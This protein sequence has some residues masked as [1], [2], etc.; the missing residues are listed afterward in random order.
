MNPRH[1]LQ[2]A[3]IQTMSLAHIE[4]QLLHAPKGQHVIR[5]EIRVRIAIDLLEVPLK[6]LDL[7]TVPL[8]V[9]DLHAVPPEVLILH[10]VPPEALV[11][12]VL[13]VVPEVVLLV[14]QAEALRVAVADIKI[15][16]PVIGRL[17][18]PVFF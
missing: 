11:P 12:V 14:V 10:A 8:E 17:Q 15:F 13:L 3:I 7:H 9:P 16:K 6:V 1:A 18:S 4:N 2:S 5:L